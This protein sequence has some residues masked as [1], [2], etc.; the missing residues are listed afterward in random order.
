MKLKSYFLLLTLLILIS[1]GIIFYLTVEQRGFW[2]YLT[3]ALFIITMLLLGLLYN[4]VVKPLRSIANGMDL[5]REQDFSSRLTPV[6]QIEADRIVHIFNRMMDQLKEERLRLRE[7]NHFLDLLVSASPMG[8]IILTFDGKISLINSAA[9]RFLGL[10]STEEATNHTL[11]QLNSIL[12]Q[13]I[14]A[15]PK[16]TT[17]TIRLSDAMIYRCSKLSFID[18][19]FAHPF[20]LIES[21][22]S[23][24]IKAEKIAYEKVIRMIAHEVN[25]TVAGITSTLDTIDGAME[26]MN[27]TEE[28]REVMRVCVER[29]F[30]MSHFI[31]NFANVVKIPEPQLRQ[32]DLNERVINCKM[33]MENICRSRNINLHL[34]LCDTHSQVAI[35]TTLFEQVLVNIIKNA[36]ESIE[37]DGDIYIQTGDAPAMLQISD[38][39]KGIN[40]E[41]EAKLFSP[42]FSTKPNGQGIGLL[43]V[44]EV[45]TSH[46]CNFSL[47]TEQDGL[48]RFRI[49]FN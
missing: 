38:T 20:I 24:V 32:V 48:T 15:I 28:L 16:D 31:T 18:R 27:D 8:V 41:V 47:R 6:K 43:F 7:Q 13:Q 3:E 23:E 45:L 36:A 12:A 11:I 1:W 10:I 34:D 30:S 39:G 17:E 21:L 37:A 26:S 9:L 2:F 40:K 14:D 5:L 35:D 33:F 4:K 49:R 19:G 29:C 25:N 22:T 46:G 44:R 42:F